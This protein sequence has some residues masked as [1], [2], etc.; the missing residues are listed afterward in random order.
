MDVI[1]CFSPAGCSDWG[2]FAGGQLPPWVLMWIGTYSI[3][4]LGRAWVVHS[5]HV[6]LCRGEVCIPGSG[7]SHPVDS[8]TLPSLWP[9]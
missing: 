7:V 8:V 9:R 1:C 5:P 2:E 6:L 4:Q 3:L